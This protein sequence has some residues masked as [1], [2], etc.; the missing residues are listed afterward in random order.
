M[1]DIHSRGSQPRAAPLVAIAL[2]CAACG[3]ADQTEST[4][5]NRA[6]SAGVQIVRNTDDPLPRGELVQPA[7]RVFG[8]E[9]EGP[10]LFGRAVGA[11]LHPNG[12]LWIEEWQ[13]QEIR[14]FD[15]RSGAHLF[16]IGGRGDGPG[17]FR[18][19]RLLG[20]DA[21]GSAYV[22]DDEHRRLS[23]FSEGGEFLRSHLLPSSLGVMPRPLHVTRAGTLMGQLPRGLEQVP[24]DGSTI[25]DTVR[26]WTIPLDGAA[27]T[28]VSKSPGALWY[29][30]DGNQ[31]GVPYAGGSRTGFW[32]D[33]VYVTDGTGTASYSVYGPAG[34]ERRVEIERAP[35]RLESSSATIFVESMR[36]RA[37][38][39]LVRMYEEHLDEM[40]MPDAQRH[41]DALLVADDGGAW[42]LR[43][44]DPEG[45][46]TDV[47]PDRVWDVFDA[48]GAFVGHVRLPANVGLEQVSGQTAL[49]TVW[50]E[51]GRVEVAIH[52]VRWIG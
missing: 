9:A 51:L 24:A 35:R 21:E 32:N 2:L 16:T 36:R 52:E 11:R 1:F 28:L 31:V 10:K 4:G 23:V 39:S 47:P 15:S 46:P 20:F 6:D 50:D 43:A 30:R 25:R 12:S 42:L 14:V 41:W 18:R 33:R 8:S 27:P 22:H 29:Y 13:S 44:A 7:R 37:P 3:V 49:T 19:S 34:L 26:V 40:P 45:Q 48:E 38:E 5:P 17:E